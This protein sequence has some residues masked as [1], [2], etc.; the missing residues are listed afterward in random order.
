MQ[1]GGALFFEGVN[2]GSY[3]TLNESLVDNNYVDSPLSGSTSSGLGGKSLTCMTC[4]IS[5]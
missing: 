3:L 5:A 2:N 4:I 1:A